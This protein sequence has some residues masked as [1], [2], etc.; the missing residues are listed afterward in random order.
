MIVNA[1]PKDSECCARSL[2]T[3]SYANTG[4]KPVS[5]K[6]LSQPAEAKAGESN[7]KLSGRK[8]GIQVVDR[9]QRHGHP[10]IPR[11]QQWLELA[12]P[13]LHDGE[14]RRHKE[15]VRADKQQDDQ[16]LPSRVQI[17]SSV[18]PFPHLDHR[19]IFILRRSNANITGFFSP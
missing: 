9:A 1:T 2:V 6:R 14:L 13:D 15:S 16:K 8:A 19:F 4:C 3:P 18:K 11:F 12:G 7:S 5:Q 10:P 17:A